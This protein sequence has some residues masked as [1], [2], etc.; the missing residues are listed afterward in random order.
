MISVNLYKQRRACE[1]AVFP[2]ELQTALLS[3]FITHLHHK[4]TLFVC[5]PVRSTH[6]TLRF[7]YEKEKKAANTPKSEEGGRWEDGNLVPRV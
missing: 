3:A 1:A 4:E 7:I 5:L 2:P 6:S